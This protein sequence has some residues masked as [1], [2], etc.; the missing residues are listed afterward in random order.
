LNYTAE[1]IDNY[2]KVSHFPHS[3]LEYFK[4]SLDGVVHQ[5]QHLTKS[6]N[7]EIGKWRVYQY[8]NYC[9]CIY[10]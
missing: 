9:P 7:D 8:D 1:S 3:S 2:A 5:S 6:Y 4:E 10:Y